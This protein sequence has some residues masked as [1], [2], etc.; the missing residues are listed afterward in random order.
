M[1]FFFFLK[2]GGGLGVNSGA[3][4][5]DRVSFSSVMFMEFKIHES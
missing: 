5:E 4:W 3:V 1:I 2:R